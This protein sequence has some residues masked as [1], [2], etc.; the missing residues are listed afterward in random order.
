LT[1]VGSLADADEAL[2]RW[3]AA[4]PLRRE[5]LAWGRKNLPPR[6]PALTGVLAELGMNFLNQSK[7]AEA[8]PVLRECLAIREG[9]IPDHWLRFNA[10]S[11]L[12]GVLTGQGKYAEAE[13]LVVGG[14][15]GLKAREATIPPPGEPRLPEAAARVVALYEAWGKPE[16]ARAWR[17]RLGLATLPADVFA[18]P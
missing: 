16:Q 7:W 2:G 6:G 18:R 1:L 4:E 5:R 10:M 13:P 17:A 14:Y 15:E 8:E 9:A 11:L 3:A 12:G